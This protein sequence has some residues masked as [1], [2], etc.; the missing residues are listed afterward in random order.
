MMLDA[1][2]AGRLQPQEGLAAGA[3]RHRPR[4]RQ[5]LHEEGPRDPGGGQHV[6]C[7]DQLITHDTNKQLND[8][9]AEFFSDMSIT[10]EDAQTRFAEIIANAD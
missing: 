8:L 3:R 7:T 1:R 2:D 9:M 6:P 10:P 5:R 4:G